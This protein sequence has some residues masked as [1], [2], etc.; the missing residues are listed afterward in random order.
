MLSVFA[1]LCH[2]LSAAIGI[3]VDLDWCGH[4]RLFVFIGESKIWDFWWRNSK[5]LPAVGQFI[6]TGSLEKAWTETSQSPPSANCRG[7][8]VWELIFSFS[9]SC[10][11]SSYFRFS[12]CLWFSISPIF[13]FL[14]HTDLYWCF[15]TLYLLL[16]LPVL[17]A[18]SSSCSILQCH[19]KF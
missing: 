4:L 14:R 1:T 7:A 18:R 6:V 10:F 8:R 2:L 12:A 19:V 5:S 15:S 9:F 17:Q 16:T 3:W 11:Y 13:S